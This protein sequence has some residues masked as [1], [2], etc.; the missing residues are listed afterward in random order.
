MLAPLGLVTV[1]NYWNKNIKE[2]KLVINT[3]NFTNTYKVFNDI[4]D[5]H[6]LK[7]AY[8]FV[9]FYEKKY[10]GKSLL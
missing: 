7:N 9:F 2:F 1:E 8:N 4:K 5:K 10:L 6:V 3:S